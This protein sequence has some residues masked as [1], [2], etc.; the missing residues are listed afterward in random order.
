[1]EVVVL[2]LVNDLSSDGHSN[3]VDVSIESCLVGYPLVNDACS[4]R[5]E[6]NTSSITCDINT[7]IIT[8]NGV[9]CGLV[10]IMTQTV[11]LFILTAPLITAMMEQFILKSPL[12]IHSVFT[13]DLAYSVDNVVKDL[14]SC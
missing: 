12:Q 2:S 8:R 10:I 14:V 13:I 9:V 4:C 5:S 11:L 1:M 6:L 3:S 7:Q